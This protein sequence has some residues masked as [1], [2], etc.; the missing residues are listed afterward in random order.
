MVKPSAM[1]SFEAAFQLTAGVPELDAIP[2]RISVGPATAEYQGSYE[3][4]MGLSGSVPITDVE[5]EASALV[6]FT[7]GSSGTP[8]GANRAHR[9]LAA[10]HY[11]LDECIPYEDSDIDLPVFPVFSLNNLA[12]GV[13]TVIPA[14]DVGSPRDTDPQWTTVQFNLIVGWIL[15][16]P[17]VH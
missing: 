8:K 10:Q 17:P 15:I 7:T 13:T 14:I 9:F 2:I 12:A 6:T 4:F 1:I 3:S 11:G 16:A 5:Q